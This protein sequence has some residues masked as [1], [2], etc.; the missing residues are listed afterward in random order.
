M[1][2]TDFKAG[3]YEGLSQQLV[4]L[5]SAHQA[6][7]ALSVQPPTAP[8]RRLEHAIEKALAQ[9]GF[10]PHDRAVLLRAWMAQSH[11]LGGFDPNSWPSHAIDFGIDTG[12]RMNAFAACPRQL[13]LYTVLPDAHW[14]ARMAEVGVPV[15]QLRF[16]SD[17]H[18]EIEKQ[19]KAA[20]KAVEGSQSLLFINDHWAQAIE[21]GAYGVHLGQED[22]ELAP[23]ERIRLA[24]LRLGLSTHGYAEML[25]ADA[26]SP[27]Y[28]ALGAVFPTTLTR[29]QTAPQGLGRLQAYARLM[30][31]HSLVAIGGIDA[32][33]FKEVQACGVGSVAVVRAVVAAADPQHAA[34]ELMQYF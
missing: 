9:L 21:A 19:V 7:E 23:T 16:K 6:G 11:R 29:M 14:V 22:L 12:S 5:H 13:G 26:F 3:E 28:I 27:S 17:D 4:A 31:H 25:R 33:R 18:R 8:N 10:L 30:Q 15:L 20:V 32:G 24:G 34:R 2:K 1:M